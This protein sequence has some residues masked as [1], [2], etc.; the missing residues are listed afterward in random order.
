MKKN[1]SPASAAKLPLSSFPALR[2]YFPKSQGK[3]RVHM[4]SHSETKLNI[5]CHLVR[6]F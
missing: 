4:L 6:A 5:G 3:A 2:P 1:Q